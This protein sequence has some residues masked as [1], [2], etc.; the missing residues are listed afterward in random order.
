MGNQ[1]GLVVITGAASGI[2]MGLAKCAHRRGFRLLLA[3][4]D[5]VGL[6]R[7]GA[8]LEGAQWLVTDVTSEEDVESL[9]ELA[10]QLGGPAL[11]FNNAGI[12]TMGFSW[13][14][15]RQQWD[16]A[17]AVNVGG[18]V[19]G[20]RSF[21]PRMLKRGTP[22]RIVNTASVGGFF[23]GPLMAPYSATKFAVVAIT[24]ALKLE[25]DQIEAPISVSLLAPGAVRSDIFAR[26]AEGAGPD[27]EKFARS[28]ASLMDRKGLDPETF[29]ERTF[30]QIER[31]EYWIIPQPEAL[32]ERLKI[33][34]NM[35]LK[36]EQPSSGKI[37][38][39]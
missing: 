16:L 26:P 1:A 35:I 18:V 28:M 29:G 8:E 39:R 12:M 13:E 20:I 22:S 37:S 5:A 17:F 19:N 33:R 4:I 31:G 15:T 36:R 11:L 32:D 7:V 30:D 2:G 6:E 21:V 27:E 34:T 24:E 3:D 25:L 38:A 14:I 9:A 10:E 23:S